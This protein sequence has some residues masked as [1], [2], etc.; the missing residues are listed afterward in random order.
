MTRK[1]PFDFTDQDVIAAKDTYVARLPANLANREELLQALYEQLKLPGYFGFNW[2]ALSDCLRDFH[3]LESRTVVLVHT[4]LPR[5]PPEECRTYLAVLAEAVDSWQPE[6]G[7][8]FRVV[9]PTTAQA[10]VTAASAM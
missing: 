9:F 2:D 1:M 8:D 5:L 4:A 10:E 6:E 7:H 3:W